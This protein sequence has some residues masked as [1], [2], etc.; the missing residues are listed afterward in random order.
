MFIHHL[1]TPGHFQQ[2]C[3][4]T[5][6]PTHTFCSSYTTVFATP[7][8]TAHSPERNPALRVL[9]HHRRLPLRIP[10]SL[11]RMYSFARYSPGPKK[12][13]CAFTRGRSMT[14]KEALVPAVGTRSHGSGTR[15]SS[16]R[17]RPPLSRRALR[18]YSE[19]CILRSMPGATGYPEKRT[20]VLGICYVFLLFDGMLTWYLADMFFRIITSSR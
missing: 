17:T 6:G 3:Y 12:L 7:C 14:Q 2:R 5:R 8:S 1:A 18:A 20:K 16:W 4:S 9:R 13:P 11:Q 15:A 19:P 10:R